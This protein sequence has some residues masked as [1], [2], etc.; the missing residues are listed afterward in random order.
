MNEFIKVGSMWSNKNS[1]KNS[2]VQ[3]T[4]VSKF[5]VKVKTIHPFVN[6]LKFDKTCF[7]ENYEIK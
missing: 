6:I 3:I 7:L 1:T 5:R 4:H 2:T